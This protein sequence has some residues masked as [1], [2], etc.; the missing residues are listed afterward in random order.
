[1][2]APSFGMIAGI[3]LGGTKTVVAHGTVDGV[4]TE[5]WRFPTTTPE[6]TLGHAIRWLR[7]RG[8]PEAVG[9]AAFGPLGVVPGRPGH[10]RM[11]ATPKPGWAGY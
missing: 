5:E 9:V 10:G 3:E 8:E 7:E 2:V 11:L 1:M 4:V 6:E